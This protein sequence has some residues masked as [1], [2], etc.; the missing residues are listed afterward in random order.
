MYR[1][2]FAAVLSDETAFRRLFAFLW[3]LIIGPVLVGMVFLTPPIQV[4]DEEHHFLRAAQIGEGHLIGDRLSPWNSGG[5]LPHGAVNFAYRFNDIRFHADRKITV[6]QVLNARDDHWDTPREQAPFP[7]TVIYAPFFYIP[8]AI[9]ID[10][11]RLLHRSALVS[12]YLGR[13]ASVLGC[14]TLGAL[15]LA[16]TNRGRMVMAVILSLPM[17]LTLCASCSQDGLFITS[18]ALWVAL[19]THMRGPMAEHR[20]YWVVLIAL[21]S[22]LLASKPP[23]IMMAFLP[24]FFAGRKHWRF[25]S[26]AAAVSIGVMLLWSIYGMHPVDITSGGSGAV[27]GKRQALRLF[28]HPWVAV[29]LIVHTAVTFGS[30]L[31]Q[32][33]LGVLGWLDAAAPLWFYRSASFAFALSVISA[34]IARRYA[35]G[36]TD[37]IERLGVLLVLLATFCGVSLALYMIWTPVGESLILGLQGRYYLGFSLLF[38]LLFPQILRLRFAVLSRGV[39]AALVIAVP[40]LCG[41]AALETLVLRYW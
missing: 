38:A 2:F 30:S 32:Q 10:A 4:P 8:Q 36:L 25:A 27:S 12:L 24:F 14:L 5:T 40:C 7:N 18:C 20:W 19:M 35:W 41:V 9:G 11:G 3:A 37:W 26:Y 33:Y 22:A 15:A 1:R 31:Y 28:H 29:T 23:Y 39:D 34:L 13:L 16:I 21:M 6:G 17:T